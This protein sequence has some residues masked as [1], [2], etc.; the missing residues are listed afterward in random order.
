MKFKKNIGVLTLTHFNSS[1]TKLKIYITHLK[2]YHLANFDYLC[3]LS[4]KLFSSIFLSLSPVM[5]V[6]ERKVH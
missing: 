6:T 4:T 2:F 5:T 3:F 1:T